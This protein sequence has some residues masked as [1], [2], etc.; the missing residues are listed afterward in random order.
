MMPLKRNEFYLMG[1]FGADFPLWHLG[2]LGRDTIDFGRLRTTEL[3][4]WAGYFDNF[5]ELDDRGSIVWKRVCDFAWY[6]ETGRYQANAI[7]L[8]L[9]SEFTVWLDL[10]DN[11]PPERFISSRPPERDETAASATLFF[12][13]LAARREAFL[14]KRDGSAS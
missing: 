12:D 4:F 6:S 14:P 11:K 8:E 13:R 10:S 7:A 3:A 5:A 2:A 1:E 9:G